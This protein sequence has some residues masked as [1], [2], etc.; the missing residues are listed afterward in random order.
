MEGSC[1][2]I[3]NNQLGTADRDDPS[4]LDLSWRLT[5]VHKEYFVMKCYTGPLNWMEE[6]FGPVVGFCKHLWVP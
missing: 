5:T 3:L 2:H 6:P 1:T 4:I